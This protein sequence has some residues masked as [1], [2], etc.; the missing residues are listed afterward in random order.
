MYSLHGPKGPSNHILRY[1]PKTVLTLPISTET[2][3]TPSVQGYF[4]PSF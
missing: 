1:L 2:L 3:D 4:T